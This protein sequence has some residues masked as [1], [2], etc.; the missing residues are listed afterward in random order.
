MKIKSD[1]NLAELSKF[2]GLSK[3]DISNKI[4]KY[5]INDKSIVDEPIYYGKSI[6][7]IVYE[8]EL[9]I[10]NVFTKILGFKKCSLDAIKVFKE[11]IVIGDGDCPACGGELEVSNNGKII[12]V[13]DDSEPYPDHEYL[14]CIN[15]NLK[16]H[17]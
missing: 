2:T 9:V 3:N 10:T 7:I 11:L 8:A 13:D 1:F 6:L 16:I 4:I 12:Q 15:C 14:E 5:F 17:K